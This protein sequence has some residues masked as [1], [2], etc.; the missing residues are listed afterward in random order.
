MERSI[1]GLRKILWAIHFLCSL[2]LE[3][4][5]FSDERSYILLHIQLGGEGGTSFAQFTTTFDRCNICKIFIVG[6]GFSVEQLLPL[7]IKFTVEIGGAKINFLDLTISISDNNECTYDIYRKPTTTDITVHGSSF[8][9]LPHKL[10]TYHYFMNRLVTTPLTPVAFK[11]EVSIIKYIAKRNCIRIDLDNMIRRKSVKFALSSTT[12]LAPL[13]RQ[14]LR[15]K[16]V[17]LPYFPPLT[18]ALV[19]LL[20]SVHLR[21]TN[22]PHLQL[23]RLLSN[24]KDTNPPPFKMWC[25]PTPVL[26]LLCCLHR[27]V[28][29]ILRRQNIWSY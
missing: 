23:G 3:I 29:E 16:T 21:P 27:W 28:R 13:S 17:S 4:Y 9:P 10:V 12:N 22:Y 19:P 20:K 11:R 8:C 5:P 25:L 14:K 7:S 26:E 15:A 6:K 2:D 1:L 24:G 18:S